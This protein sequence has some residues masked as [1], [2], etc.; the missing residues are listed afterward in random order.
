MEGHAGMA[1]ACRLWG[2]YVK[3][4]YDGF[5]AVADHHCLANLVG[6]GIDLLMRDVGRDIDEISCL[7]FRA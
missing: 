6:A 2:F 1:L 4:Y 3:I 5:S 7:R